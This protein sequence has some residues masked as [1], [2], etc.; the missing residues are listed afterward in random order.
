MT[1]EEALP[2]RKPFLFVDTLQFADEHRII[3]THRFQ[4]DD[5]FFQ[6]HFPGYPVVPGVLLIEMMAQVGGAGLAEAGLLPPQA[7]FFLGTIEK[8][9]FR[10]QVHPG[11]TAT[12]EIENIRITPHTVRQS[13]KAFVNGNLCTEATW[14]CLV[15][16][17]PAVPVTDQTA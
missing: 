12:I 15:G 1:I 3:G 13:G 2:H 6:G 4:P 17:R 9:K 7:P 8:A 5:Y 16:E 14:M 10:H 11:D